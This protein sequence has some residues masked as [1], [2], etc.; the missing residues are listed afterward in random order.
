MGI[1]ERAHLV[2]MEGEVEGFVAL[3]FLKQNLCVYRDLI[4]EVEYNYFF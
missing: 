4:E 1:K 2:L 3:G